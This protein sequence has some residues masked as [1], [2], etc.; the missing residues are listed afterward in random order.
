MDFTQHD[1]VTKRTGT[2]MLCN[3]RSLRIKPKKPRKHLISLLK[4]IVYH[5][6][7]AINIMGVQPGRGN[8]FMSGL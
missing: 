3:P 7:I 6:N 5:N 1:E 4:F 8:K 2:K